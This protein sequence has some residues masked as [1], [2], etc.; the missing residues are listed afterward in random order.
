MLVGLLPYHVKLVKQIIT[1]D[2]VYVQERCT[3]SINSMGCAK[4]T[5][6]APQ[7]SPQS[8]FYLRLAETEVQ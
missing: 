8:Q 7:R 1:K 6:R 4:F 3:Q 2:G 5:W